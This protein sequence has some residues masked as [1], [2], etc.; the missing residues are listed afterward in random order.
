[1]PRMPQPD[2]IP[3]LLTE[4]EYV[5]PR[6]T[7]AMIGKGNLDRIRQQALVKERAR[8]PSPA[9]LPFRG[10]PISPAAMN[11][12]YAQQSSGQQNTVWLWNFA[13]VLKGTMGMANSALSALSSI[14]SMA[15]QEQ[16]EV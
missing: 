15:A 5:I 9:T 12:R 10:A 11:A 16:E 1:M 13:S 7:V 4:G 3:A 2:T 8:I 6:P 14:V